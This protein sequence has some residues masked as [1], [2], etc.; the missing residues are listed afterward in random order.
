MTAETEDTEQ[1]DPKKKKMKTKMKAGLM[2]RYS[3][4][5]LM[6]WLSS[7]M[8]FRAAGHE[9]A[10]MSST[11]SGHLRRYV[12]SPLTVLRQRVAGRNAVCVGDHHRVLAQIVFIGAGEGQPG[13]EEQSSDVRGAYSLVWSSWVW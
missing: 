13:A 6:E 8:V 12:Q 9:T 11:R 4:G 2:E 10:N 5:C 3:L 7:S 1:S